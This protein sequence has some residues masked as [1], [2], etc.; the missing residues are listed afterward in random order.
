MIQFVFLKMREYILIFVHIC[1]KKLQ[2]RSSCCGSLVMNL[3]SIHGNMG[4]IPQWVKGSSIA[5]SYGVGHRY[6]LDPVFLWLWCRSE[7]A[8]LIQ[9]LAWEL[10]YATSIA[11]KRKKKKFLR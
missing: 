11:L 10:P 2:A 5:M 3:T 9:P 1:I 8:A 6:G 7:A 4:L